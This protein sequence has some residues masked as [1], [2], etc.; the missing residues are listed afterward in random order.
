M[1][2]KTIARHLIRK[3]VYPFHNYDS[4][5]LCLVCYFQ[6]A[7][8]I[9]RNLWRTTATNISGLGTGWD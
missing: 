3:I 5:F 2:I 1:K 8:L 4:R 9:L 7:L 6:H